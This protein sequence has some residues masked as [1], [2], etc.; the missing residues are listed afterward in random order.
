MEAM[1]R[2]AGGIAHDFNNLLTAILGYADLVAEQ[3]SPADPLRADV[4]EIRKAADR[5]AALTRQLLAFSRQQVLEPQ[6]LDVNSIVEGVVQLIRRLVGPDIEIV[7]KTDPA[8]A[9][10]QADAGQLEQVLMN[11]AINARDAMDHGGRLTIETANVW[12]E[13]NDPTVTPA[14]PAGPHIV[15]SVAD[16]GIGM[17]EETRRRIFEPFF[18]TKDRGK[19]TGLGLSTV[20]GIIMQSNGAIGV[21]SAPH[22]GSTFRIYLPRSEAS[23]SD[24]ESPRVA[25]TRGSE[26]VLLV[27]DEDAVRELVR[28]SLERQGF[29]VIAADSAAAALEAVK[30]AGPID[31]MVTDVLMPDTGGVALAERVTSLRPG[32]RV[33]YI[34]GYTDDETLARLDPH[35]PFLQKPF[36]PEALARKVRE[37]LDAPIA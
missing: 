32:M 25:M 11:L 22:E 19:G 14:V 21:E 3:L 20:Y 27:E 16:T 17:D 35:V 13:A 33:L 28:K 31:L 29:R 37:T 7:V 1:G 30:T 8:I 5:G 6:V 9:L 10:V 4:E 15:L 2:L 12:L 36:T 26:T 23:V 24:K 34:S 18:T